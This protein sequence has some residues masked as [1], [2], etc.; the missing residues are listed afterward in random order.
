ME[1]KQT[2]PH[3]F[4]KYLQYCVVIRN[5]SPVTIAGY[6]STFNLF[7]RDT[8][9][10]YPEEINKDNLEGWFFNGRLNRK[11]GAVTFRHHHKHVNKFFDWLVKQGILASNLATLIEKPRLEY[12]LPRT[13][14]R[15]QAQVILDTAYHMKYC[16]RYERYRN[17]AIIG[18][19]IL[20]GLRKSEVLHLKLQDISLETKTI[21]INQGKGHKDRMI[22]INFKLSGILS[23]YLK[24]RARLKKNSIY[25]FTTVQKDTT[26]GV[27]CVNLLI[28]KL[29]KKTKIN[30]SAHTLRHGFARLML[31]GGCDI[32]TLSKM[33]GHNK[34]TTT[35]IYLSCSNQQMS[36]SIEMHALN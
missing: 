13:V 34:I 17:H 25:F 11:W 3:L 2:L 30:F 9:C 12:K 20:A 10:L 27:H 36:K 31:E 5:Y 29:R 14:S 7:F 6:K 1:E 35:T 21:F 22:P 19:M 23:E 26:I 32:Y 33:M 8:T 18:L 28:G 4:S 16:Y 24:D 15:E